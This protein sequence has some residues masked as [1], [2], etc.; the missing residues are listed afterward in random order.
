MRLRCSR[1]S[2]PLP[3]DK[4]DL[5]VLPANRRE[6]VRLHALIYAIFCVDRKLFEFERFKCARILL[7]EVVSKEKNMISFA[8]HLVLQVQVSV[9]GLS[10]EK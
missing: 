9:N 3:S 8:C 6:A 5:A 10:Y 2:L 1:E 7:H 4:V